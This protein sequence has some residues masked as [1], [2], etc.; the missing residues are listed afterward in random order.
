VNSGQDHPISDIY[1]SANT[2]GFAK[3]FSNAPARFGTD[4]F[5]T[6]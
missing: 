4:H 6:T 3:A 5:P 1:V 2:G